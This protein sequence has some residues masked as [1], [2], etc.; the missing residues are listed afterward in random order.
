MRGRYRRAP[1]FSRRLHQ[2]PIELGFVAIVAVGFYFA[3]R[4]GWITLGN[5]MPKVKARWM[6][7]G[8][9]ATYLALIWMSDWGNHLTFNTI[10]PAVLFEA[11]WLYSVIKWFKPRPKE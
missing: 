6:A 8:I 11:V 1:T 9:V 7:S 4:K 5:K 2:N 3:A 10:F